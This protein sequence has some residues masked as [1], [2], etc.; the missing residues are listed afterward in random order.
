MGHAPPPRS[1]SA[2]SLPVVIE[3]HRSP[4]WLAGMTPPPLEELIRDAVPSR[5]GIDGLMTLDPP[6]HAVFLAVHSW[7]T[8]PFH[9]RQDL[10]D[11]TL[12]LEAPSTAT[13]PT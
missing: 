10:D 5:L 12:L 9:R 1:T 6:A 11:I 8:R 2:A 7:R 3:V 13:K 4:G